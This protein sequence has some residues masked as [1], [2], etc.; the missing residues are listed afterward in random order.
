[1]RN[2]LNGYDP[3][4][5]NLNT[6]HEIRDKIKTQYIN[7]F[8]R[9]IKLERVLKQESK[10][11]ILCSDFKVPKNQKDFLKKH[12]PIPDESDYSGSYSGA[13]VVLNK[14]ERLINVY[15]VFIPSMFP[16]LI[17]YLSKIGYLEICKEDADILRFMMCLRQKGNKN[18]IL[19]CMINYYFGSLSQRD[20]YI[21]VTTANSMM[22]SFN[23]KHKSEIVYVD[24]DSIYFIDY[25]A[26][27]RYLSKR[28]DNGKIVKIPIVL[29]LN[30]DMIVDFLFE[31]FNGIFNWDIDFV[32]KALFIKKK[33]YILFDNMTHKE[34]NN[35]GVDSVKMKGLI[36]F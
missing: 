21:V 19:K 20:R 17:L 30:K 9:N 33:K 27:N 26:K 25:I 28:N 24:T 34:F 12:A 22:K 18:T 16:T 36:E 29:E 23:N 5:F 32:G 3:E 7:V 6:F 13:F 4:N 15:E 8:Y 10:K 14:P 31:E 11:D 2:L 1:M 35:Y